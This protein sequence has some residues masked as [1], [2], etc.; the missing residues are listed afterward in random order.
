MKRHPSTGARHADLLR[1]HVFLVPDDVVQVSVVSTGAHTRGVV[2]SHPSP[3]L[4]AAVAAVVARIRLGS[5]DVFSGDVEGEVGA[6]RV[7]AVNTH[8][9]R[10]GFR[11]CAANVNAMNTTEKNRDP[12]DEDHILVDRRLQ[13]R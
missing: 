8:W 6:W 5:G 2:P 7:A 9:S 11:P 1:C 10:H 13:P 4:C 3:R 12:V